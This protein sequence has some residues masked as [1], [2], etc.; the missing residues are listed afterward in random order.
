MEQPYKARSEQRLASLGGR[1]PSAELLADL[2]KLVNLPIPLRGP[3][4]EVLDACLSETMPADLEDR[5]HRFC[6]RHG[7][8][9]DDLGDALSAARVLIRGAAALDLASKAFEADVAQVTPGGADLVAI[10]APAYEDAKARLRAEMVRASLADHGKVLLGV[11]WRVDS[12]L[13]SQ[14]GLRLETRVA[15]LTFRY[16]R[17]GVDERVTFQVTPEVLMELQGV[18]NQLLP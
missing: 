6:A 16:Q 1:P 3:L 9:V 5:V 13:S 18:C 17:G 8:G 11:D 2:R 4:S 15:I 14:R 10:L 12:V 7:V